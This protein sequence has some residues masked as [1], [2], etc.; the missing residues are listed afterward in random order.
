MAHEPIIFNLLASEFILLVVLSLI[1]IYVY[2]KAISACFRIWKHK[3]SFQL[4]SALD[5][6]ML[7]L[8]LLG[9]FAFAYALFVE[10]YQLSVS[11]LSIHSNKLNGMKGAIRLVH[12]TDIHSDGIIRTE[13]KLPSEVLKLSPDLVVFTG[14]AANTKDGVP[15]FKKCISAI[16]A[17]VPTFVVSGNHDIRKGKSWKVF[18]G[19]GADNVDGTY[20]HL[21]LHGKEVFVGG[22]AVDGEAHL[23]AVLN[24]MPKDAFNIL[25]YHYPSMIETLPKNNSVDLLCVGH[26]HGGQ[27]RLP[28]Y[29]AI[30]TRSAAGKKYEAGYYKLGAT[31]MYVSRGIGMTGYSPLMPRVRFCCPPEVTLLELTGER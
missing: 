10:P 18:D 6:V 5:K 8:S 19:T 4:L 11:K 21:K 22:I 12:I 13:E 25:F 16:S 26:T 3:T 28:G 2:F 17:K 20:K 30:V 29:G 31:Q 9:L 1:L 14:D 24:A 27:V 15:V 23:L 7:V